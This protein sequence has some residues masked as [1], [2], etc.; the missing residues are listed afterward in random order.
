MHIILCVCLCDPRLLPRLL[1][2]S[3][4]TLGYRMFSPQSLGAW[5]VAGALFYATMPRKG[6]E[7]SKKEIE[8]ANRSNLTA[9]SQTKPG[10]KE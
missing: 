9:L 2:H 6:K 1:S 5:A 7:M 8:D 3:S 10:E 4:H